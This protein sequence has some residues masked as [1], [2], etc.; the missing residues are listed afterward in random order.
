[1]PRGTAIPY[2]WIVFGAGGLA[3][4][5]VTTPAGFELLHIA[6][7]HVFGRV[8]DALNVEYIRIYRVARH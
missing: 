8:R 4:A 1:V 6:E 3:A 2:D 5:Q 7:R